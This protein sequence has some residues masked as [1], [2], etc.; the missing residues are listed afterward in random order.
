MVKSKNEVLAFNK[1][2]MGKEAL[3]RTDL[4]G[5]ERGAETMENIFPLVQGGM[6]KM[7]GTVFVAS[8]P[9]DA[10][11]HLRP[12]I[13]SETDRF[14]MEFSD[15]VLRLVFEGG[16]VSLTG[17]AATVGT[18]TDESAVVPAGGGAAPTPDYTFTYDFTGS[19]FG[20]YA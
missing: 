7:P 4:E 16:L 8:T 13:F 10:T 5:Y 15:N 6:S 14:A 19:F 12:F 3:A 9:S 17:A 18:F 1:G 11:A 2:E 20:V